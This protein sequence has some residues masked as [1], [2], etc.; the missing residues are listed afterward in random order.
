MFERFLNCEAYLRQALLLPM[1]KLI[2][3]GVGF[4]GCAFIVA[5]TAQNEDSPRRR[6]LLKMARARANVKEDQLGTLPDDLFVFILSLLPAK[7]LA[8]ISV[9]SLRTNLLIP[10]A[11]NTR[12][13][14]FGQGDSQ[15]GLLGQPHASTVEALNAHC[16]FETDRAC[17][18]S[19]ASKA[20]SGYTFLFEFVSTFL[21]C[22][23]S[24]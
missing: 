5:S 14:I 21:T 9:L 18:A 15:L 11:I 2:T 7:D 16:N 3:H 19:S 20:L 17:P 4:E 10:Q 24:H 23:S 1:S 6:P 12:L 8:D 22:G 13:K